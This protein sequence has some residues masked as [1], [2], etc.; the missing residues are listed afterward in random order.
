MPTFG[1]NL[2]LLSVLT[3]SQIISCVDRPS[4]L[5]Q[6]TPGPGVFSASS[7]EP[8]G[9]LLP[10]S[11]VKPP[12]PPRIA[13]DLA[14]FLCSP[15]LGKFSLLAAA[16]ASAAPAPRGTAGP[17]ASSAVA[18]RQLIAVPGKKKLSHIPRVAQFQIAFNGDLSL[19]RVLTRHPRAWASSGPAREPGHAVPA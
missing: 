14:S 7:G 13:E 10:V 17:G 19:Q 11:S 9:P 18:R 8:D 1:P 15:P 5:L 3:S 4:G 12:Y 6:L 2:R 16:T